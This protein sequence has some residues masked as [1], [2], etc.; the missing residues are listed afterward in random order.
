[1]KIYFDIMKKNVDVMKKK[2]DIM[3]VCFIE[4]KFTLIE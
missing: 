4:Y 3:K 2:V 1:M